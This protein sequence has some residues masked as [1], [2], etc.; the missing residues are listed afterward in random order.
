M[1]VVGIYTFYLFKKAQ[2]LALAIKVACIISSFRGS[3]LPC[4]CLENSLGT[5][6]YGLWSTAES[7]V[8][9]HAVL[10]MY[11]I[12]V[13]YVSIPGILRQNRP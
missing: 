10:G 13:N 1:T 11:K 6:K 3:K 4:G 2:G 7:V 8:C 9:I 12:N 5:L